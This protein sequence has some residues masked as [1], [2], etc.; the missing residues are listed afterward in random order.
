MASDARSGLLTPQF[1]PTSTTTNHAQANPQL[2]QQ[3]ANEQRGITNTQMESVMHRLQANNQAGVQQQPQAGAQPD[4]NALMARMAML[5]QQNRLLSAQ[6]GISPGQRSSATVTSDR[7]LPQTAQHMPAQMNLQAG[8]QMSAGAADARN[9]LLQQAAA[10]QQSGFTENV[11]YDPEELSQREMSY[12][13][14][15]ITMDGPEQSYGPGPGPASPQTP[16]HGG[17]HLAMNTPKVQQGNWGGVDRD[18]SKS[19]GAYGMNAE[20]IQIDA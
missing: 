11:Q 8:S 17:G 15:I 14:G 4:I 20:D 18:F 12:G 19:Q 5:E 2:A 16:S 6:G 10:L 3:R 7:L 9:R 13:D 1:R